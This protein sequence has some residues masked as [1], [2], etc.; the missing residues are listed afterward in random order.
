MSEKKAQCLSCRHNVKNNSCGACVDK[1]KILIGEIVGT[2][3]VEPNDDMP[4]EI[5]ELKYQCKVLT[6][7]PEEFQEINVFHCKYY[8]P[9]AFCFR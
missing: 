7:Y 4:K 9:S 2:A 1:G 8:L 5:N 3:D 6:R